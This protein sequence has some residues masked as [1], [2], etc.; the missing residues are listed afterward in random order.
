M[1]DW[2]ADWVQR[3]GASLGKPTHFEARDGKYL[4]CDCAADIPA[5]QPA[6][7]LRRGAA[8]FPR[9]RWRSTRERKLDE[10]RQRALT[11]YYL[12][13]GAGGVAVG[14]HTTQFA[15]REVGLYEPVLELA[16]QTAREWEPLGGTPAAVHGGGPRGPHRA[17]RAEARIARGLG[18]HAGLL[19]LAAMKGASEDE[20]IAHCR[21]VAD[22]MP[23]G[24]LLPAAGGRRL[25]PADATSGAASPRSRTSSRSRSRRSTATARST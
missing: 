2:T 17:G 14:V 3:G 18:Y 21:A 23:A 4:T 5:R 25:A 9:T 16:M 22:V 13:A 7:C 6:P 11:R 24:R 8:S 19:S 12:D 10:R 20:L 15:I 1:I